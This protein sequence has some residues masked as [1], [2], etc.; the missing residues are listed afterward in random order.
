MADITIMP[1]TT[2]L[3][4]PATRAPL[5]LSRARP[6]PPPSLRTAPTSRWDRFVFWLT[7]PDALD[8]AP[9][10]SGL[11]AVRDAFRER[12]VDLAGDESLRLADQVQQARTLREL[13][14]L[15]AELYRVVALEHSQAEA[16]RRVAG[17]D[18]H[19]TT[20]RAAAARVA[21]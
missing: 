6:V 7:A 3:R 2:P 20:R 13:W 8:A 14:H 21:P 11:P 17:L 18:R 4:R 16:A 19:F 9:P 1:A 15:R 12:M 5:S 10:T